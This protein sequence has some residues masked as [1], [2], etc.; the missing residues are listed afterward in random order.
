LVWVDSAGNILLVI[1]IRKNGQFCCPRA[2]TSSLD[3]LLNKIFQPMWIFAQFFLTSDEVKVVL[4]V[5]IR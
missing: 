3:K 1:I 5:A 4:V 2:K